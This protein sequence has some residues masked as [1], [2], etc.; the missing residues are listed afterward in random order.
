MFCV[1]YPIDVTCHMWYNCL[2]IVLMAKEQTMQ[3]IVVHWCNDAK[4]MALAK[5]RGWTEDSADSILDLVEEDEAETERGFPTITK[6]K[7]WAR[8]NKTRDFWCQ[9]SV[10][11]Y[12]WP[13]GRRMSWQRE[14]V[15]HVRYVGDGCGWD[16]VI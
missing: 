10:R 1:N 5:E 7:E 9:P 4:M 15:K 13:D 6:A 12:A 3:T 14:T 11:V 8:R 2:A 16:H